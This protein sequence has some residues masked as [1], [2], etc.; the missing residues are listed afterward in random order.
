MGKIVNVKQLIIK[1]IRSF[2]TRSEG[3]ISTAALM[4]NYIPF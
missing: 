2:K 1:L 3:E 4:L